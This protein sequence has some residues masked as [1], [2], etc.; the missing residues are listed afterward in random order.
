MTDPAEGDSCTSTMFGNLLSP[1]QS[2]PQSSQPKLKSCSVR[3]TRLKVSPSVTQH[4]PSSSKDT[5]IN[6]PPPTL[7]SELFEQP[8]MNISCAICCELF[9]AAADV[10]ATSCGH[11]FH[12]DCLTKWIE[13]SKSC[14]QCRNK[15]T[16]ETIHRLYFNVENN[17]LEEDIKVLNNRI[18]NLEHQIRTKDT[19][20]ENVTK[21]THTLY[22]DNRG[23]RA[24]IKKLEMKILSQKYTILGHEGHMKGLKEETKGYEKAKKS[25]NELCQ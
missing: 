4:L 2:E 23:L 19:E 16:V 13:R 14:P 17:K 25:V 5:T 9:I 21:Q 24:E 20:M 8:A 11:L 18:V 15:T 10:F 7:S 6:M 22:S 3:L 12:Y 1:N